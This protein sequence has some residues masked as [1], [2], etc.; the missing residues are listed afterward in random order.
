NHFKERLKMA[1]NFTVDL[2]NI[3]IEGFDPEQF[4]EDEQHS[5]NIDWETVIASQQNK[6]FLD[7]RI[8]GIEYDTDSPDSR[9]REKNAFAIVFMGQLKGRMHLEE[10]GA[11]NIDQLRAMVGKKI[12]YIVKSYDKENETF[13][14][15]RIEAKSIMASNT[16]KKIQDI[17]I[18]EGSF[19]TTLVSINNKRYVNK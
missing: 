17:I 13:E 9:V 4:K 3:L 10:T 5:K 19:I 15:S 11:N 14:P 8:E 1:K 2:D 12:S 7:G 16:V 18:K 6:K